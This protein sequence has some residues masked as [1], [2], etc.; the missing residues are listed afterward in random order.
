MLTIRHLKNKRRVDQTKRS[1]KNAVDKVGDIL[2][3]R[4]KK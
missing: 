4:N 2:T 3:W 1:A